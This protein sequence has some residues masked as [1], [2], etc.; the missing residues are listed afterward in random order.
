MERLGLGYGALSEINP[1]IVYTS[2]SGFGHSGPYRNRPSFDLIAQAMG[3]VMSMTG[4]K[5]GPPYKVGPGIGDIWPATIAAF[6]TMVALHH[7]SATGQGQHIDTK[8]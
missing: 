3:G 7:A 4:P 1:K 5:N 6:A 8:R 2:I